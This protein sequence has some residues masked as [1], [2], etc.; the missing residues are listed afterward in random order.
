[1]IIK[2]LSSPGRRREGRST[3]IAAGIILTA[4]EN[5]KVAI[6]LFDHIGTPKGS[7][8]VQKQIDFLLDSVGLRPY[9]NS[10]NSSSLVMDAGV[11]VPKEAEDPREVLVALF[12][13][14]LLDGLDPEDLQNAVD[15]AVVRRVI[16]Q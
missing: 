9:Q 2:R 13:R 14:L 7:E 5:P 10:F 15:E 3:S 12:G 8:I 6:P 16:G 11:Q 4:I 1:M